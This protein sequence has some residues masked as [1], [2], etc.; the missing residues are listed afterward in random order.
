M[1]QHISSRSEPTMIMDYQLLKNSDFCQTI[2]LLVRDREL[3]KFKD[4]LF[5]DCGKCLC[6]REQFV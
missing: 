2:V 4:L 3:I 6:Y 1:I 5:E